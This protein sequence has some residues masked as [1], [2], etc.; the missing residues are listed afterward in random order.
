MSS[1]FR[2]S[3][4][5][6]AQRMIRKYAIP[7]AS[8]MDAFSG[9]SRFAFSR[10][11]VACAGIPSR[12]WL[13]P[14]WKRSYAALTISPCRRCQARPERAERER[15]PKPRR[16]P[17]ARARE[18][19]HTDKLAPG[20]AGRRLGPVGGPVPRL[21]ERRAERAARRRERPFRGPLERGD[22]GVRV[23]TDAAIDERVDELRPDAP[24]EPPRVA[25]TEAPFAP[26]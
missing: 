19:E 7:S 21:G 8:R 25:A 20:A 3:A 2:N 17:L 10:A 13:R 23:D 15:A 24:R 5:A 11:T 4:S 9:S 12:R 1:T 22:G 26:K 14:C 18:P 16:R 6:S